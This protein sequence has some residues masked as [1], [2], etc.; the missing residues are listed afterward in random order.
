MDAKSYKKF[1]IDNILSWQT[2]DQFS[3]EELEK[4]SIR[5]LEIIHDN[6]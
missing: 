3:R 6:I 1:L 4:K 2:E 5:A